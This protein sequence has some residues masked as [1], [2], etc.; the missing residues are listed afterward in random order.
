MD[1]SCRNTIIQNMRDFGCDNNTIDEFM[2]C[3][4]TEDHIGQKRILD[5]FRRKLISELHR[6]QVEIDLL[7]YLVYQLTKCNCGTGKNHRKR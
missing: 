7:D 6:K 4:N 1:Y 2:K 5:S 3:Y